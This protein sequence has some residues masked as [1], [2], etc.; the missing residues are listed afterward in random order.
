MEINQL[1]LTEQLSFLIG[2]F[3]GSE[4]GQQAFPPIPMLA[5]EVNRSEYG[6]IVLFLKVL[7]E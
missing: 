7:V 1:P 5:A 4:K 3:E 2:K 6:L